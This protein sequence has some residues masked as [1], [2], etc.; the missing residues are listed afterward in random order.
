[1]LN[2]TSFKLCTAGYSET[3]RNSKISVSTAESYETFSTRP[4]SF[5]SSAS[6]LRSSMMNGR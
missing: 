1:M 3:S 5:P 6:I 2:K 4:T